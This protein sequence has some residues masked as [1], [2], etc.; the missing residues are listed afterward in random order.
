MDM[1]LLQPRID[2]EVADLKMEKIEKKLQYL[3]NKLEG[4]AAL[5]QH[6]LNLAVM[7]CAIYAAILGFVLA[8][9]NN[10]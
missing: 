8:Y 2:H 4:L 3:M 1:L 5:V 7:A 9:G 10:P 6:S